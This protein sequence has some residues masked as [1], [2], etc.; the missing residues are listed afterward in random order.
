MGYYKKREKLRYITTLILLIYGLGG[1]QSLQGQQLNKQLDKS[2]KAAISSSSFEA[3]KGMYKGLTR[4]RK[5]RPQYLTIIDS[6]RKEFPQDTIL[7]TENYDFIC[8]GCPADFI[9][10]QVR[11]IYITLRYNYDIRAFERKNQKITKLFFDESRYHLSDI[12]ELRNE[13]S[14]SDNWNKNPENY[15]TENCLDGGHT[16]YSFLYPDRK[17]VSMYMRC[18]IN[19]ETRNSSE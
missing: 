18:W 6:L 7:L 4:N 11:E 8:I 5:I 17:I 15:G 2:Q 14:E 19:K 3:A 1:S 16:F 12:Q 9:Q 10:I 13:I